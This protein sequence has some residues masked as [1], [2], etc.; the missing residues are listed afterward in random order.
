MTTE[1]FKCTKLDIKLTREACAK[2]YVRSLRKGPTIAKITLDNWMYEVD[3]G[4]CAI[5][6]A[7]SRGQLPDVP[8]ASI[9]RRAA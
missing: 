6:I 5:G 1:F 4:G 7:H 2:R 9:V 3:C 8:V